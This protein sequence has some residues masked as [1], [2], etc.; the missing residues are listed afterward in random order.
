MW[1]KRTHD[2]G[3]LRSVLV[4]ADELI[5]FLDAVGAL[6]GFLLVGTVFAAWRAT[7]LHRHDDH[8]SP[9]PWAGAVF[10]LIAALAM[11]SLSV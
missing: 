4:M 8:R 10:V 11:L 1:R 2:E 3:P 9:L 7:A 5:A 6:R